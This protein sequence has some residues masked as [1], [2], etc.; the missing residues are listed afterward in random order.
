MKEVDSGSDSVD[1]VKFDDPITNMINKAKNA[2]S[3]L[4]SL[5]ESPFF[6][7]NDEEILEPDS[8]APT[9]EY[10]NKSINIKSSDKL[11]TQKSKSPKT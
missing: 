9:N 8:A 3:G 6:R 2:S 11:Q 5:A 4:K 10:T 1:E 7:M